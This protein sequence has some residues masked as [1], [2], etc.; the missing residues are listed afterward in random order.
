MK[1]ITEKQLTDLLEDGNLCEYCPYV[2]CSNYPGE[3][4]DG[5]Y[6]EDAKDNYVESNNL[7]YEED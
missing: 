2:K 4:C 5:V 7:E 6:C 1:K 3:L